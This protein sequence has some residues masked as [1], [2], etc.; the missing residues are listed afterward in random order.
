MLR[1]PTSREKL[2]RDI[3]DRAL[4]SKKKLI[5]ISGPGGLGKD[6]VLLSIRDIFGSD[7]GLQWLFDI[8]E[9]VTE[10][11]IPFMSYVP[12]KRLLHREGIVLADVIRQLKESVGKREAWIRRRIK[13]FLDYISGIQVTVG[14]VGV[15]V[16]FKDGEGETNAWEILKKILKKAGDTGI[17]ILLKDMDD[18]TKFKD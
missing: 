14:P 3:S 13:S 1:V 8:R 17:L 12:V 16:A 9:S 7:E 2:I 6:D 5:L 15:G 4:T 18:I 11:E 10:K